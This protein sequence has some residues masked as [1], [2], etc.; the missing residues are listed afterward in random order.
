MS[1][2]HQLALVPYVAFSKVYYVDPNAANS[3]RP[4]DFL[5]NDGDDNQSSRGKGN[6]RL[7]GDG[8]RQLGSW[9]APFSTVQQCVER[10]KWDPEVTSCTLHDGVYRE[11]VHI[12]DVPNL[13]L[14]PLPGAK[15]IF[16]G[17]LEVHPITKWSYKDWLYHGYLPDDYRQSEIIFQASV[18]GCSPNSANMTQLRGKECFW[19]DAEEGWVKQFNEDTWLEQGVPFWFDTANRTVLMK[20][21]DSLAIRRRC[22]SHREDAK[23]NAGIY[24]GQNVTNLTIQGINFFSATISTAVSDTYHKNLHHGGNNY[25]DDDDSSDDGRVDAGWGGGSDSWDDRDEQYADNWSKKK[26]TIPKEKIENRF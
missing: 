24:I 16:D 13:K 17:S 6:R 26:F 15:P 25:D 10:A 8:G 21:K 4:P 9:H 14:V 18:Q 5:A 20:S 1:I 19:Y 2:W 7:R 23:C 3:E 12:D 11:N 22:M